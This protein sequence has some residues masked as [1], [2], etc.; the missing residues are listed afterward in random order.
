MVI[1]LWG[2]TR[3]RRFKFQFHVDKRLLVESR[4]VVEVGLTSARLHETVFFEDPDGSDVLFKDDRHESR[5][6]QVGASQSNE[7]PH[8]FG[9][10]ALIPKGNG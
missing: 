10:N 3:K 4:K 7:L 8:G 5:E 2:S 6:H 9:A 1:L